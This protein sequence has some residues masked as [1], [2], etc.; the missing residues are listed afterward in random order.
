MSDLGDPANVAALLALLAPGFIILWFRARVVEGTPPDFKRELFYF[1]LA[2]AAYYGAVAPLFR[3][4]EGVALPLW[5][6]SILFYFLIPILLG[7]VIGWITQYDL[8]YSWAEKLGM[9]FAHRIPTA[10]D[11]RFSRLPAGAFVLVTLKDGTTV[12]G[13]WAE[14]SFAS[15]AKDGRD[16]YIAE[17]W[18]NPDNGAWVPLDPPRG[19]LLCGGDIRYVETFGG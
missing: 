7:V 10:W 11:F 1:A 6:W 5:L 15:S 13:R 2:S 19:M 9:H 14:T 17:V 18:D 4:D 3:L 12:A 8:E 16:I